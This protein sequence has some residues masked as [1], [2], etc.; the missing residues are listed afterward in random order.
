MTFLRPHSLEVAEVELSH[1]LLLTSQAFIPL[2]L[3]RL[4]FATS[5][6]KPSCTW[7]KC[8]LPLPKV[9]L[10]FYPLSYLFPLP[11]LFYQLIHF[12]GSPEYRRLKVPFAQLYL[13]P[14]LHSSIPKCVLHLPQHPPWCLYLCLWHISYSFKSGSWLKNPLQFTLLSPTVSKTFLSSCSVSNIRLIYL[15]YLLP[16][17]ARD[18][19]PFVW[20]P[21][22]PF[23]AF[24][25]SEPL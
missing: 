9:C 16:A 11:L 3:G 18:S 10:W 17:A 21:S 13:L 2:F 19:L 25:P 5:C 24:L 1:K 15:L 6:R 22:N 23:S 8:L 7:G 20:M 4:T 12:Q 14:E